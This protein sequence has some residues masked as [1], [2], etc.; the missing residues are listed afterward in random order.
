MAKVSSADREY[1]IGSLLL[2]VLV[3]VGELVSTRP[4]VHNF[5]RIRQV[6]AFAAHGQNALTSVR[7]DA[8][9]RQSKLDERF[10]GIVGGEELVSR[11]NAVGERVAQGAQHA[12]HIRA[13]LAR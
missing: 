1:V 9:E 2:A 3:S 13:L 10:S 11:A 8:A 5:S 6:T 12:A 7:M 4:W